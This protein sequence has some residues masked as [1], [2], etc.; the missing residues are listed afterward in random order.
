MNYESCMLC[1]RSCGVDRRK[2]LGFCGQSDKIRIARYQKHMWEEPCISGNGGSGT[3][4]FS[5][6]TLKC[7]YCQNYDVSRGMGETISEKELSDIFLGLQSEG[8]HNINLVT[9][10]HFLPGVMRAIDMARPDLALPIVYNCGG[11]E[12]TET[13]RALE[14]YADVFIPDFKYKNPVISQKYSSCSDYYKKSI[15]AIGEMLMLAPQPEY[16]KNGMMKKGVIIRHLVLP[17]AYKD[18]LEVLE[19]IYRSFGNRGFL[20]SLMSQYTPM[21][22]C[23]D[24]PE[25]NRPIT[26]LEYRRVSEKALELGFEGYFQDIASSN[27]AYIPPFGNTDVKPE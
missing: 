10:T 7:V 1:P 9:A 12:R 21:P 17:G 27:K 26:R 6:C 11:Y 22:S 19:G 23:C 25:I 16:D 15:E 2:T 24:F 18:S 3:V 4:F 20:L 5:G 8:C 14:G 13:V